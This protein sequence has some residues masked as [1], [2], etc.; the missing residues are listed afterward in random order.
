MPLLAAR[1]RS[2]RLS[3]RRQAACA[4]SARKR[5]A[6]PTRC[7]S[8]GGCTSLD[9]WQQVVDESLEVGVE[10][11]SFGFPRLAAPKATH[12]EHLQRCA[13]G[14]V[15]DRSPRGLIRASQQPPAS[16]QR[17]SWT[18]GAAWAT[19]ER[20]ACD[21]RGHVLVVLVAAGVAGRLRNGSST[22]VRICMAPRAAGLGVR[23]GPAQ[24]GCDGVRPGRAVCGWPPLRSTTPAPTRC[25]SWT[26]SGR[27]QSPSSPTR[28]LRSAFSG[29]ATPCTSRQ[30]AVSTAYSGF[31]GTTFKEHHTVV[32]LPADVGEV[33]GLALVERRP[34]QPGR[35]GT[36]RLVH[37][38]LRGLGRGA[39]VPARWQ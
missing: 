22:S 14:E 6:I 17:G 2:H 16:S 24:R 9:G 5:A 8:T 15:G 29:S 30:P 27:R 4:R 23:A 1:P 7:R 11:L 20:H 18:G 26:Q 19:C 32:A 28:T 34:H 33:N 3:H 37:A 21:R 12:A 38:D 13:R 31:D 25:T 10:S 35:V 36:M 39:L